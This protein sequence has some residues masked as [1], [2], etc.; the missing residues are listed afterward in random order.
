MNL[1][2]N[3]QRVQETFEH[4]LVLHSSGKDKVDFFL[5]KA[6]EPQSRRME[7]IDWLKRIKRGCKSKCE[8]RPD[9][10]LQGTP[11]LSPRTRFWVF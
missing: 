2:Y 4:L 11:A 5:I 3:E 9:A 8:R 10:T 7:P 6:W 1:T